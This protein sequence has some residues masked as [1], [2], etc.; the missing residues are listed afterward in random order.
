MG[1]GVP[2]G[3]KARGGSQVVAAEPQGS[4]RGSTSPRSSGAVEVAPDVLG[5]ARAG[6]S[7]SGG[8]VR[9][10]HARMC[11]P[12]AER[13]RP[14]P[15]AGGGAEVGWESPGPSLQKRAPAPGTRVRSFLRDSDVAVLPCVGHKVWNTL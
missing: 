3:R 1:A 11:S 6:P 9:R 10:W 4:G 5:P 8:F 7:S 15:P 14:A 13:S 2:G 12:A